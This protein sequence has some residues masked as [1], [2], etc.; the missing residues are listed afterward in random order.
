MT[1][2]PEHIKVRP[3][4]ADKALNRAR[5]CYLGMHIRSGERKHNKE[6]GTA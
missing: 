4:D 5:E 1:L 2:K 3:D 6:G